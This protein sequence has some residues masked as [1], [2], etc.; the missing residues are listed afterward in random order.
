MGNGG[1]V[2]G[3]QGCSVCVVCHVVRFV[4]GCSLGP[5]P[6]AAQP[7]SYRRC[8]L[9]GSRPGLGPSLCAHARVFC[10]SGCGHVC[11]CQSSL[12]CCPP[13]V[14]VSSRARPVEDLPLLHGSARLLACFC[15]ARRTWC[16]FRGSFPS[17]FF[18]ASWFLVIVAFPVC[19]GLPTVALSVSWLVFLRFG[20]RLVLRYVCHTL[21]CLSYMLPGASPRA[22]LLGGS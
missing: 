14:F 19:P 4:F 13:A 11:V 16:V 9:L 21:Y 18:S 7:Y 15:L 12:F 2:G 1:R 6:G 5:F 3:H 10:A 20:V 22:L 17:G 8:L